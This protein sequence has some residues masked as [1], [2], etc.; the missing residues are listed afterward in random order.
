[1]SDWPRI[2]DWA[3]AIGW[4]TVELDRAARELGPRL[5][6]GVTF[7]PVP[8]SDI[9]GARGRSARVIVDGLGL[10]LVLLEPATEGR[11]AAFLARS[12]EGWA[13][14]WSRSADAGP[15]DDPG[16]HQRHD[17]GPAAGTFR[18]GPWRPG[19]FGPER[20]VS[21]APRAGPFRLAVSTATIEP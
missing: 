13:A 9:L 12:G 6:A 2:P 7:E 18:E 4:A 21:P 17:A 14:I 3:V 15:R 10:A 19:P 5:G 16:D 20:L 1:M 8:G 11:L